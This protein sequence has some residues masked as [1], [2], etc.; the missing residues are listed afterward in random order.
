MRELWE[1]IREALISALPI[2]VLGYLAALLPGTSFSGK[3]M[4]GFTVGAVLLV[5]GIG[6]FNWVRISL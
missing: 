6:F 4:I 3:E 5:L 2:T 1:E